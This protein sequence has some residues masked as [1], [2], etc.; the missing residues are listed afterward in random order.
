MAIVEVGVIHGRFQP[1][2]IG[3]MEYLLAGKERSKFLI[4][5]IT[6]PDPTLTEQN[7]TNPL[8]S[9][10]ASN[11]FT[12]YERLTMIRASLLEIGIDRNE[13][14]IVPFP[15]NYPEILQ[16]YVPM[17]S[18]FYLTIYDDWGRTKLKILRSQGLDVEV[19]WERNDSDR[20][21]SATEVRRLILKGD[22]WHHLVP[23]AVVE[24]I[25]KIDLA[26]RFNQS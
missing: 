18:R 7:P 4:V 25:R 15:I 11:P 20:L 17:N 13:F 10:P 8:R 5:G 16:Y 26:E 22:K 24:V 9:L 6:N 2:H 23:P 1:L 21:T 14:E 12:Y 19:M 3:H